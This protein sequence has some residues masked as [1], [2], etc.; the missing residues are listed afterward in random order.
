MKRLVVVYAALL[1]G[2]VHQVPIPD[3]SNDMKQLDAAARSRCVSSGYQ[4]GTPDFNQCV[5]AVKSQF[6]QS[7]MVPVPQPPSITA[8]RPVTTNC[9]GNAFSASCT[10]Y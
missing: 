5:Y 9:T 6:L 7:V 3:V 4:A 1:A 10:T 2:C 8:P